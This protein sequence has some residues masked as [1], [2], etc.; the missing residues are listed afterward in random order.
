MSRI[1]P[2]RGI[3]YNPIKVSGDEVIAPPYD[4]ISP[5]YREALYQKSPYNIVRI[6]FGKEM[7]G[8]SEGINKYTRAK[9]NLADWLREDILQQ[10]DKPCFYAC[11]ID[12]ELSGEKK[13]LRGILALVKIEELGRG[14]YPH[15]ATHAKPKT[16]RLNL[17]RSCLANISPIY[18]MY[19]SPERV[20]SCI[21]DKVCEKEPLFFAHDMDGAVHKLYKISDEPSIEL[22]MKELYDKSIFI[23]DGHH[24]YEVALEFKKEMDKKDGAGNKPWDYVMM[25]L[26][27]MA[28]EGITILS[29][30]RLVKGLTRDEGVLK[31]LS[32]HFHIEKTDIPEE[33]S[34]ITKMLAHEGRNTFGLY[35]NGERQWYIVKY[36]GD[37]LMD[38]HPALR[39]LDVVILHELILKRD[40][41]INGIA[42]EMNIKEAIVRVQRGDF[43]AAF[44]LNPTEAR[45]VEA[46]ALSGLRMPP[47]STYFYPKLLTGMVIN[48]FSEY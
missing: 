7:S 44:F 38:M 10:D 21:L 6:D 13:R 48:K 11:E 3:C 4:I 34:D 30:H 45:D 46:V 42:Y 39:N 15:E 35:V 18:S 5:E 19:N 26:A 23:A 20:T 1:I 17:M 9:Q 41:G 29:A 22:I 25:F 12:Y 36:K 33:G 43:D 47:K 40:L 28:D 24:R 2:F 37:S 16:D 14:I 8:D 27:N 31:R 32:S